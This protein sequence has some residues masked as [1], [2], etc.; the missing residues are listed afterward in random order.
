MYVFPHI[1]C[2]WLVLLV[3]GERNPICRKWKKIGLRSSCLWLN[4]LSGL[5]QISWMGCKGIFSNPVPLFVYHE[6]R[7][8][9]NFPAMCSHIFHKTGEVNT[10]T[11]E[12][13]WTSTKVW[14]LG[15]HLR[16]THSRT[17]SSGH[18][19][20]VPCLSKEFSPGW[21]FWE[22]SPFKWHCGGR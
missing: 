3:G 10:F 17:V 7:G 15:Q 2:F 19:L 4:I 1:I 6:L 11:R 16:D 21:G 5:S 13:Q 22:L 8:S 20:M 14:H 9:S 18:T 12:K